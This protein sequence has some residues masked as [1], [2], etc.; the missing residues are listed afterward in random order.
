MDCIPNDVLR[1]IFSKY[2]GIYI[3]STFSSCKRFNNLF[4]KDQKEN[5]YTFMSMNQRRAKRR[6]HNYERYIKS[7]RFRSDKQPL[8]WEDLRLE[9]DTF[10]FV[11]NTPTSFISRYTFGVTYDNIFCDKCDAV[12]NGD[13][14]WFERYHSNVCKCTLNVIKPLFS[15]PKKCCVKQCPYRTKVCWELSKHEYECKRKIWTCK[16]CG[17]GDISTDKRKAHLSLDCRP[18]KERLEARFNDEHRVLWRQWMVARHYI[19]FKERRKKL[20]REIKRDLM[21]EFF[22]HETFDESKPHI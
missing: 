21:K 14:S 17:I 2:L 11:V 20:R 18:I 5:I 9:F 15:N 8:S 4:T 16:L 12:I 22:K 1:Y 7:G 6:C 19:R 10:V 3:F 13:H